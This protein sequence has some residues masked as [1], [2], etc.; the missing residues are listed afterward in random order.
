MVKFPAAGPTTGIL[1][2]APLGIKNFIKEA[3]LIAGS[4]KDSLFKQ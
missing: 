4:L 2:E 3:F 1:S